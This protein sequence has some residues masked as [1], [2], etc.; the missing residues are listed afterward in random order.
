MIDNMDLIYEGAE[1]TLVALHG[2]HDQSGLPGVSIICRATKPNFDTGIDQLLFA[3]P[4]IRPLIESS[5]WNTR[6]WTYQEARFS[7]PMLV[8][9]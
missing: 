2:N 7:S 5:T 4:E 9:Q 8:L 1:V 3:F 6:G